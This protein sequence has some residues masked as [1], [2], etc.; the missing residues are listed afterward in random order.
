[1]TDV[2]KGWL[3]KKSIEIP[4][5]LATTIITKFMDY[6]QAKYFKNNVD[7]AVASNKKLFNPK[8]NFNIPNFKNLPEKVLQKFTTL[9]QAY[10]FNIQK[11]AAQATT[12][13]FQLILL[14]ILKHIKDF[15][16]T[17]ETDLNDQTEQDLIEY[18]LPTNY[19]FALIEFP[20]AKKS[21]CN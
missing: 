10:V 5:D 21:T 4:T 2:M 18:I 14:K 7:G 1:M 12:F 13:T 15:I 17:R 11:E 8:S 6:F 16:K 9:K 3:Q 19:F 20:K